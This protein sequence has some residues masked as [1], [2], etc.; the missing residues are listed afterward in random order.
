MK[1]I[2][3]DL[4][5]AVEGIEMRLRGLNLTSRASTYSINA[6]ITTAVDLMIV[7]TIKINI[8]L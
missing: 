4:Q 3:N 7:S 5:T 8:K 1:N 6:K 2:K